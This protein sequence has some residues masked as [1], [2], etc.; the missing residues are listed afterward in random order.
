MDKE[1]TIDGIKIE[2]VDKTKF[3]GVMIDQ[4]LKFEAH[5]Q[6]IKGKVARGI[7]I[8]N[9]CK[10]YFNSSTLMTL[11]YSFIYPY[12]NYCNCIWGNTCT[13]YLLPLIK[14]QKMAM[15][16]IEGVERRAHTESI[17]KKLKV[18]NMNNLYVYCAQ[19]FLF[20]YH[21][22]KLPAIFDSFFMRN[23][24]VHGI[25]TR[26]NALFRSQMA[27]SSLRRRTI[28]VVGVRIY[29]YFYE[30]LDLNCA[31]ITYKRNLKNHLIEN[32]VPEFL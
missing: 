28:R 13:T 31:L 30:K 4:C 17:F 27:T 21:Y 7:G 26:R 23:G 25:N 11:Y 5:I 19:L 6:F 15:R 22:H 24:V 9:K 10:K 29:N 18:L 12:L 8:L 16:I 32:N 3:L 2:M 20:K 14:L 1:L